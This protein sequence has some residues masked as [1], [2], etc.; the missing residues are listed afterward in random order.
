MR[1]GFR[2]Y[3]LTIAGRVS[4]ERRPETR[5]FVVAVVPVEP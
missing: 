5:R 4:T 1:R 2:L 3:G